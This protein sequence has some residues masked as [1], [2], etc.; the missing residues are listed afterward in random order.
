MLILAITTSSKTCSVALL[1][2][3]MV[4]PVYPC[5]VTMW[6]CTT[7]SFLMIIGKKHSKVFIHLAE[8]TFLGG[9]ICGFVGM[10]FN[11]NFLNV[12][13]VNDFYV[14][15]GLISH[16]PM[17]FC[18]V[19][20]FVMG[21]VKI[22]TPRNMVSCIIGLV[23]FLLCAVYCKAVY[24]VTGFEDVNPMFLNA[25]YAKYPFL[26]FFTAFPIILILEF[27]LL[28]L[29]ERLKY[30]KEERWYVK[31]RNKNSEVESEV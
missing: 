9:S 5:N 13:S 18:C 31:I 12:P 25:P 16:V 20:L 19:Y 15:K 10:A 29:F 23:L 17:E 2:D 4:L 14:M 21:Y 7:L 3:N 22:Y 8:F 30:P 27:G 11:I 1:E 24:K 28:T 26:N 6:L